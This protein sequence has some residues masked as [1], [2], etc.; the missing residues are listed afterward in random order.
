MGKFN[1]PKI[2]SCILEDVPPK[3]KEIIQRRFGLRPQGKETLETI[4]K[5]Y[6]ITRERVRQIEK[7]GLAQLEQKIKNYQDVFRHFQK[8]LQIDGNLRRED[9]LISQL[10]EEE[11][12]SNYILFLLTLGKPFVRHN[13]TEDFYSFWTG[14]TRSFDLAQK[15]I[16]AFIKKFEEAQKPLRFKE[17]ITIYQNDI[18][19][20][21]GQPLENKPLKSF[22]EISKSIEEGPTGNIGLSSWAEI[23]PRGVKDKAYLV[24]K[25]KNKPLHFTKVA[26]SIDQIVPSIA[27]RGQKKNTLPQTVHN[28]L[29]KDPR[30]V[31][32]G[33]GIYALKEWGY[34]AGTVKDIIYDVLE[35]A[36]IPLSREEIVKKVFNERLVKKNTVLLNLQ[37]KKYFSKN[38]EGKYILKV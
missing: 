8:K 14:D 17:V 20:D 30:F 19:P 9:Q 34:T 5:S 18:G 37:N 15:I 12:D 38:K 25:E 23:R 4:G 16:K 29:I 28:E 22:L 10:R 33:R 31:L 13:T 32:V 27:S 2:C 35:K 21:L 1:Y 26:S 36:S 11:Q 6:G 24:I 7:T 3:T